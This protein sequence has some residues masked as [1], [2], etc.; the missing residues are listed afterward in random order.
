MVLSMVGA[1]YRSV[2][3]SVGSV[4]CAF[5]SLSARDSDAAPSTSRRF[6]FLFISFLSLRVLQPS[7][8]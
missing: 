3:Y 5:A 1:P 4:S 7:V 2:M 8:P 6:P